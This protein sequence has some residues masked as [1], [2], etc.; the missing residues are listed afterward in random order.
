MKKVISFALIAILCLSLVSCGGQKV[1]K[2]G[3]ATLTI[4]AENASYNRDMLSESASSTD[5][6]P[7]DGI[8][9]DSFTFDIYEDESCY[10]AIKRVLQDLKMQVEFV[11]DQESVSAYVKG[12]NNLYEK[13]AGD[14]SGWFYSVNNILP[15]V[16]MN[17]YYL[18]DGDSARIDYSL[19]YGE[20]LL[21]FLEWE[22]W[23]E[24]TAT[25]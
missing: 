7:E 24:P 19:N 8:I 14:Q 1:E 23:E 15:S 2:I 10:E 16:G 20:D 17:H 18:K 22:L 12:L 21:H 11:G 4:S 3:S 25:E 6:V 13:D 9:L 5:I